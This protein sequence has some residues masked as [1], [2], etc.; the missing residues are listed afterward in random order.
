[1][2]ELK[3]CPFCE[4]KLVPFNQ[5]PSVFYHNGPQSCPLQEHEDF[6]VNELAEWNTRP[7]EDRLRRERDEALDLY[8][9]VFAG[10]AALRAQLD[11]M[12]RGNG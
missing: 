5:D 4:G 6:E 7:I 8:T 3:P 11:G 2:N 9:N 12:K 10:R 1:M